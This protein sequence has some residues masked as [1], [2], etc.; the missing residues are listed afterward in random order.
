MATVEP[1][2]RPTLGEN[3]NLVLDLEPNLAKVKAD[4]G[5]LEQ[6]LLNLAVNARDAMPDG[7]Q[8]TVAARTIEIGGEAALELGVD[9]GRWVRLTVADTGLGMTP[10][11]AARAF[12]P[13][14]TTKPKGHGTGLGLATVFGIVGEA[15]GQV[16][17]QSEPGEGTSV[18]VYL[19]AVADDAPTTTLA[20]GGAV[21]SG[22]GQTVM[23]VEDEDVMREVAR[24]ILAGNG[25]CVVPA[26][27][28]SEALRLCE[29]H[30]V[31]IDLILTDVVMPGL[32]G[33]DLVDRVRTV[34]PGLR[35]IYMSGYPEDFVARRHTAD[36]ATVIR[37]PFTPGVLLRHV[38]VALEESGA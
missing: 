20:P 26:A 5:R 11:V 13:F 31:E 30:D 29:D 2:L 32:S 37:K 12:E 33:P 36:D 6:V 8:L 18:D 1:L 38:R 14:F 15:G 4:A 23:V 28:A 27:D 21:P 9:M 22:G 19:P 10:S 34:R 35:A 25:Y 16:R 7:G 24:R 3:I 17:L